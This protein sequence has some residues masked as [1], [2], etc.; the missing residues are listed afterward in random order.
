MGVYLALVALSVP[1]A[2]NLWAT[3]SV[4]ADNVTR[5]QRNGQLLLIWL[6]AQA[7]GSCP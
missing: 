2:L 4:L 7:S 1:L 6:P 5:G 3:E